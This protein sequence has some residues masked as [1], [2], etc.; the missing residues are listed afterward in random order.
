M[1]GIINLF[2]MPK[3]TNQPK[4]NIERII[5]L[6]YGAKSNQIYA[7]KQAPMVSNTPN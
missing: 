7:T 1:K 6:Y 3:Q 4:Q 5:Y 2:S